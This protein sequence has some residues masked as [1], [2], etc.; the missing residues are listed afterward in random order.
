MA[1]PVELRL[2]EVIGA[3]SYALDMTDGQPAGHALRSCVIGM[4]LAER[5]ELPAS[6]RVA[7]FYGLL[8]KDAG[9]SSNAAQ[10]SALYGSDDLA[11]KRRLRTV[12]YSRPSE[13]LGY[14][15]RTSGGVRDL[16]RVARA[17]KQVASTLTEIRCERGA[18][19]A[20]MLDLPDGAAEAIRTLGEHWD[21]KGHP[22]G[23]RGEEIPVLA[24]IFS[25][26]Q[27]AEVFVRDFGVGAACE[28]AQS[29]RGSWFDPALVD[30]LLSLRD[31]KAFW[32]SLQ[33][34]DP[35]FVLEGLEPAE[36]E[37]F[38][39]DARLDRVAQAFA[40]VI[41]AKSPYTFQH[42]TRVAELSALTATTLGFEPDALRDLRRASLLHDIGKL[43]VPNSIL[44]KPA[45]L[46]S[47]ERRRVEQ[48][49]KLSATSSGASPLSGR[50][51][52]LPAP[53]T[54]SS[55]AAVTGKG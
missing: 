13:A 3:L 21:G 39:D 28:M 52:G 7:V 43:A 32:V 40:L 33:D 14:V 15:L 44:D 51:R 4:K 6:D 38:A 45:S 47:E 30:I 36:H 10:V 37:Q 9:C 23:L 16:A 18:E 27:T 35:G 11:A 34:D 54:R 48:H 8:M 31:E 29:R 50:S 22:Q 17:G 20:R 41:D 1:L 2:S 53:T 12:N 26:A 55:M 5:C 19:I 49:P 46:S 42:S 24:R 25:L